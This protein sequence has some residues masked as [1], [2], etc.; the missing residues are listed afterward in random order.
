MP[1]FLRHLISVAFVAT[2]G[3]G[4]DTNDDDDESSL[5]EGFFPFPFFCHSSSGKQ[6]VIFATFSLFLFDRKKL[7]R[8][9]Q[10]Q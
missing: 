8:S 2:A 5:F 9:N 1:V 3:A 6:Q 10:K 7:K 4:A